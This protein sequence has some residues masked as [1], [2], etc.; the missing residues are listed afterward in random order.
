MMSRQTTD[1]VVVQRTIAA[2][3]EKVFAAWTNPQ[4]LAQWWG[5]PGYKVASVEL[6]LRVN[7]RYRIGLQ[8]PNHDVFFISGTYQHIQPPEKLTFTWRWEQPDMDIGNSLVTV[9]ITGSGRQTNLV[10]THTQL[11]EPAH[12]AHKQGWEGILDKLISFFD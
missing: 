11:P 2:T 5:P 6:D 8:Q 12:V 4:L 1:A 7:G 10:L 3:P 9:E